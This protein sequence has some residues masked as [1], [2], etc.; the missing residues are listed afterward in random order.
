MPLTKLCSISYALRLASLS[1]NAAAFS[2][3]FARENAELCTVVPQ[4]LSVSAALG[5]YT[6]RETWPFPGFTLA[7]FYDPKVEYRPWYVC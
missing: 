1:W 3:L 5:H 7:Q 6:Q 2:S 4:P